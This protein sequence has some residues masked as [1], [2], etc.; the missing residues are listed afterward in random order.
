ME[1][2]K[3]N[4]LLEGEIWSCLPYIL[5]ILSSFM[6]PCRRES[7]ILPSSFIFGPSPPSSSSKLLALA[8]FFIKF[9]MAL[10]TSVKKKKYIFKIIFTTLT[11]IWSYWQLNYLCLLTIRPGTHRRLCRAILQYDRVTRQNSVCAE[12]GFC[13]ATLSYCKIARQSCP[14]VPG[15]KANIHEH[16]HHTNKYL[17]IQS[18]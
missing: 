7:P 13:R 16:L 10:S 15:L 5:G 12:R 3:S 1:F 18:A 11:N 2:L 14:C 17:G 9:L 6:S 4:F 8:C